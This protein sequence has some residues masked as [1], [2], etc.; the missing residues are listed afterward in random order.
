MSKG[1]AVRM[2]RS[3]GVEGAASG[4]AERPREGATWEFRVDGLGSSGWRRPAKGQTVE[5]VEG[6]GW[7]CHG[8]DEGASS[9]LTGMFRTCFGDTPHSQ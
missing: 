4:G 3:T 6:Q 2:S 7:I 1:I 5:G 9:I 8:E